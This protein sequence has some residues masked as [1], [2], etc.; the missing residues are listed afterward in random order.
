MSLFSELTSKASQTHSLLNTLLN[1]N[2]E[3]TP[4]PNDYTM[5]GHQ[6]P[7]AAS[8]RMAPPT[9]H[10][11]PKQSDLPPTGSVY[12]HYHLPLPHGEWRLHEHVYNNAIYRIC[13]LGMPVRNP[14]MY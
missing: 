12:P 5:H 4:G 11:P 8:M 1:H 13:I 10:A 7:H 3:L 6:M 2:P 9:G 14:Y